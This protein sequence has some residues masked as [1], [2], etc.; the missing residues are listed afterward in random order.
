LPTE[1]TEDD[2]FDCTDVLVAGTDPYA[3][4][5]LETKVKTQVRPDRMGGCVWVDDDDETLP[6][7]RA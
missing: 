4:K 3:F 1:K 2:R 6:G 7:R 5:G